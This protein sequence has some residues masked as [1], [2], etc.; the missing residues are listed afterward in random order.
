MLYNGTTTN[1]IGTNNSHRLFLTKSSSANHDKPFQWGTNIQ[2]V[3]IDVNKMSLKP[4]AS[5]H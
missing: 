1:R 4:R 2:F 5:I 3:N